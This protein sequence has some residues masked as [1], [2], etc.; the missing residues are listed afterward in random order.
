M[1]PQGARVF[2]LGLAAGLAVLAAS[3]YRRVSPSWLRRLLMSLGAFVCLRYVAV[4]L[5]ADAADP[6]QVWLWRHAW[7]ATSVGLTLPS[8]V[9]LDQLLRHPAMTPGKLLRAFAPFLLA[10]AAV[11]LFGACEA[12]PDPVA[13]WTLKLAPAW[14][15]VVSVTQSAFVLGFTGVAGFVIWKFPLMPVRIALGLLLLAHWWLAADGVLL[16]MGRWYP[17]PF[18]YSE[19]ATLLALTFA[20]ETAASLQQSS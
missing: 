19:M 20:F 17:W 3:S 8:I 6:R 11:I 9:A 10:Y 18:L 14:R 12:V 5:F 2:L 7:F 1:S 15:I 4:A 16:A 13:G